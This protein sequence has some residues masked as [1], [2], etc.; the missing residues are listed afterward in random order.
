VEAAPLAVPSDGRLLERLAEG[1]E[2]AFEALF[3]RHYGQVY[4]VLFRMLGDRDEAEDAAQEVFLKLHGQRFPR[5][6]EHTLSG[7]LYRVAS[8]TALNRLR[9]AARRERR[10]TLVAQEARVLGGEEEPDPA[11]QVVREEERALVRR[12]LEALPEKSRLCLVLRQA[13]LSYAE[14]AEALGVAPSSVGT[15]LSRAEARFREQYMA[16]VRKEG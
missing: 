6:R 12:A 1:D 13:G 11:Q 10:E 14:M 4:G 9:G 5:G 8:N 2:A 7:W 16:I 15:L 3:L